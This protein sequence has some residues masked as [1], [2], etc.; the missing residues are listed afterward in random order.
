MP[1][2]RYGRRLSLALDE[3]C[4]IHIGQEERN[5]PCGFYL[6]ELRGGEGRGGEA[7]PK[8]PSCRNSAAAAAARK[9]FLA[10]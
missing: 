8:T 1:L 4:M 2:L 9:G 10:G 5:S 7:S 6:H 3:F